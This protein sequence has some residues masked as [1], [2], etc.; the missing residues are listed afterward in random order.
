MELRGA[1]LAKAISTFNR[2]F[3]SSN[4]HTPRI[5]TP[6]LQPHDIMSD[7]SVRTQSCK[8]HSRWLSLFIHERCRQAAPPCQWKPAEYTQ[9]VRSATN[10]PILR[11]EFYAEP[12]RKLLARLN[13]M[14]SLGR[15]G[16]VTALQFWIV[17]T[18]CGLEPNL[19]FS[20]KACV[21]LNAPYLQIQPTQRDTLS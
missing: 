18:A 14:S 19:H 11:D 1:T 17:P 16:S 20:S 6:R 4:L 21:G 15:K 12:N 7:L 10:I 2:M 5:Q 13:Q 8:N 9:R 3:S